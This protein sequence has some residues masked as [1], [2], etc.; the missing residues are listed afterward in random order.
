MSN[1]TTLV[2]FTKNDINL[3]KI[4]TENSLINCR[5]EN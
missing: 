4:L 2:N 5:N 1:A 3:G